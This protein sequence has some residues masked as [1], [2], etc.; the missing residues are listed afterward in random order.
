MA[1]LPHAVGSLVEEKKMIARTICRT[2][3]PSGG[4]SAAYVL[5][6]RRLIREDAYRSVHIAD[7][8]ARRILS[9]GD[10]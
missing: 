2:E 1:E 3:T 4:L 5:E 6:L 9:S 7:E 10:L 8:I